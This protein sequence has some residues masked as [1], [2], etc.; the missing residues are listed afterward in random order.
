MIAAHR[1]ADEVHHG[2][3]A[4][5]ALKVMVNHKPP[6]ADEVYSVAMTVVILRDAA[7][8][9]PFLGGSTKPRSDV[10]GCRPLVHPSPPLVPRVTTSAA[11]S[12]LSSARA[13][14]EPQRN[15]PTKLEPIEQA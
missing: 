1:S 3:D 8:S 13:G 2:A 7:L 12:R 9:E 15:T 14:P 10:G 4:W 5:H 6:I 11:T